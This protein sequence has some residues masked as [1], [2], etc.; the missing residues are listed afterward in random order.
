MSEAVCRHAASSRKR[1]ARSSVLQQPTPLGPS[2]TSTTDNSA[3][4]VTAK[5]Q[6]T[7]C[8]V[9][10]AVTLSGLQLVTLGRELH[11]SLNWNPAA[12]LVA[13]R[14][15]ALSGLLPGKDKDAR[16]HGQPLELPEA[17]RFANSPPR[18]PRPGRSFC[19]KCKCCKLAKRKD[20]R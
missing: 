9:Q 7:T 1:K 13:S 11:A 19:R 15:L 12:C 10:D 20:V 6:T 16:T 2:L 18:F 8:A 14:P 3:S 4:P 5:L 17:L